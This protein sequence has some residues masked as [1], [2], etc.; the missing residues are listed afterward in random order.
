[1]DKTRGT[2]LGALSTGGQ[3]KYCARTPGNQGDTL[4][5]VGGGLPDSL[6]LQSRGFAESLPA[7][8][9]CLSVHIWQV[10]LQ[11]Q[12]VLGV[13]SE[14]PV[15]RQAGRGLSCILRSAL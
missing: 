6:V 5:V 8:A 9:G 15:S 1:M 4:P 7:R 13:V 10:T 14:E 12:W 11:A 2:W 3:S